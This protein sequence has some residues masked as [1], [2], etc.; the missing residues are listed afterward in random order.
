MTVGL[1]V[2]M[3]IRGNNGSLDPSALPKNDDFEARWNAAIEAC[4]KT[5]GLL[6]VDVF[7]PEG[8]GLRRLAGG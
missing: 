8:D 1:S 3:R 5:P 2:V 6:F 7:K 4:R